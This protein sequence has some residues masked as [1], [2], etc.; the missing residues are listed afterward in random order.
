MVG[1]AVPPNLAYFLAKQ[2]FSDL[3]EPK[4]LVEHIKYEVREPAPLMENLVHSPV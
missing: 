1:N 3:S 4:Q 2:I